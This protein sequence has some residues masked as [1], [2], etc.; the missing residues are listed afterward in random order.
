M[1]RNVSLFRIG[2]NQAV[3]ILREFELPGTEAIMRKEGNKLVIEPVQKP[4]LL[5]VV[6][7]MEPLDEQDWPPG[8]EDR[9]PDP[10]KL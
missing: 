5:D 1:E 6:A 10:V 3:R 7:S 2:R 9:P 8:I 4:T